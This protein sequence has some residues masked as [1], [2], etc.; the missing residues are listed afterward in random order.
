E[1]DVCQ[2]AERYVGV[3]AGWRL[4]GDLDAANIVKIVAV[5]GRQ[6]HRD[7]ELAIRFQQRRRRRSAQGRLHD[8]VDVAG[9]E[10]VPGGFVAIDFDVQIR[11]AED[12][13]DAEIRYAFDTR[14]VFHDLRRDRLQRRQIA[15][16][17]FYRMGA[18]HPRETFFDVI[19][20]VLR[21]IKADA[22]E[23]AGESLLQLIDQFFLRHIRRP[24]VER[25]ERNKELRVVET[26]GVAAVVRPAAVGNDGDDFR[27][28]RK[29]VA[30]PADD[31]H[32]GVERYRRRHCRANPQIAFFE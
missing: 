21:E 1:R 15:P 27:V 2:L 4:I 16:D 8:V 7:I 32:A 11:L 30:Y 5:F 19:L 18:F 31:R 28:T 12:R 20:D 29:D 23:L 24:F 10:T 13:K 6:P 26:G 17:D 25:F 9:V 14:H 22:H 3:G